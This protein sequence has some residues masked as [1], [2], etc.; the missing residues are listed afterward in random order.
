MVL[1][2][3]LDTEFGNIKIMHSE[4]DGTY[5]YYQGT[6]FHSQINAEGVSTYGYVHV[7]YSIIRQ[8]QVRRVLMI[9]G[10]GGTLATMLHRLGCEVTVVDINPYAFILAKR[11]FQMPEVVECIVD[12]GWSYL[13]KTRKRYD[14][15]VIDA[16]SSDGSI[17][18]QFTH[19]DFFA[20]AGDMVAPFGVVVMNVMVDHDMDRA[21]DHIALAMETAGIA[22]VLFDRPGRRDRNVILAGGDVKDIRIASY[23]K[24]VLVRRELY[25]IIR[26]TA[27]K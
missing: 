11:Y 6:C 2:E 17:P 9:G 3:N 15:I 21:A 22:T 4:R 16:F 1:V 10:A 13:Q 7:M 23:R 5:S 24:P 14:A 20:A 12:D 27:K 8:S 18:E 26:R 25:G 19:E